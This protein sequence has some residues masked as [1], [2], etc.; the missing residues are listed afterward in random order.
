LA[1]GNPGRTFRVRVG[2]GLWHGVPKGSFLHLGADVLDVRPVS[3]GDHVGYWQSRVGVDGMLV[4]IGAGSAAGIAPLDDPDPLRRS[5]F[6]FARQRLAL[7]E[8]PHMHTSLV[9]VPHGQ[10]CP[11][12]GDVVDVQRPL[13]ATHVDEVRWE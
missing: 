9:V 11:A 10:A 1:D 4:A 12:V 7:V 2:T 8:R 5:P 3:A 6:H 13:I